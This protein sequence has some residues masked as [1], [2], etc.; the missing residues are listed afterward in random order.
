MMNDGGERA[1][2]LNVLMAAAYLGM[3]VDAVRDRIR[4]GRIPFIRDGGRIRFDRLALDRHMQRGR[5][6]RREPVGNSM[7]R[8]GSNAARPTS[9]MANPVP[10]PIDD[11]RKL[12]KT[13]GLSPTADAMVTDAAQARGCSRSALIE[14]CIRH[15]LGNRDT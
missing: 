1:R 6:D 2:Y 4:R 7:E 8:T 5:I 10:A 9:R 15:A 12:S 11:A 3:T 14:W 13:V